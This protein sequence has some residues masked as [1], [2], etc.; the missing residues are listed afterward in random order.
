MSDDLMG[1]IRDIVMRTRTDPRLILGCSPRASI[2]LLG[3]SKANAALQGRGYVIPDDIKR[4]LVPTIAHRLQLRAEAE[5]EGTT[6]RIVIEDIVR[7]VPV[8]V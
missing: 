8:P 1:Y 7:Q 6:G 4:V 5:L 2:A 3:N